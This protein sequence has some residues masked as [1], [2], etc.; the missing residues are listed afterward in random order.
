[1]IEISYHIL[2]IEDNTGD[3]LLLEDM[4]VNT[5]HASFTIEIAQRCD[6]AIKKLQEQSFDAILL[7]LSLPDSQGI[8]TVE[9]IRA[10]NTDTPII[11]LTGLSDETIGLAT[12]QAGAQD[13]LIKNELEAHLVIRAI[14]FGIERQRAET[15]TREYQLMRLELI[16]ER[17]VSELKSQFITLVSH[18]FRTP[19]TIINTS[20]ELLE[21]YGSRLSE[22]KRSKHLR[23]IR[24]SI[25]HITNLLDDVVLAG[26][27]QSGSIQVE[28][29]SFDLQQHLHDII[30]TYKNSI[31]P[32]Q[33]ILF[34]PTGDHE[35]IRSDKRFVREIIINL[36]ENATTYSPPDSAIMVQ[37]KCDNHNSSIQISDH[38]FGIPLED[39]QRIFNVFYRGSNTLDQSG[40]GLGL[41][42][43]KQCLTLLNGSIRFD[44]DEGKGTTFYVTLPNDSSQLD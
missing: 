17:E 24:E 39:Q 5:L 3:A 38:G 21:T 31:N 14:R 6:T 37:L 33:Q 4:L 44:T 36:L 43:A 40:T 19:L 11:V 29:Q 32:K 27:V 15:A 41:Y 13:Y 1:M 30:E 34:L 9:R 26:N 7:D 10:A 2:L 25:K 42:I 23:N 22:D 35:I 20:S 16:K 28:Y 8:E 12:L 18:E